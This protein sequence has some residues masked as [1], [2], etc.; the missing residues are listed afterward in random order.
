MYIRKKIKKDVTPNKA[1]AFFIILAFVSV[2]IT[3]F[4]ISAFD[5]DKLFLKRKTELSSKNRNL[6]FRRCLTGN[7]FRSL[8]N[9]IRTHFLTEISSS[10]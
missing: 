5:T 9:I 1:G 8:R 4:L 3:L 7:T 2:I 10:A 6:L